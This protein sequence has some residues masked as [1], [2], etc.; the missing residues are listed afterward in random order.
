[1][2]TLQLPNGASS[3]HT[4][5]E[6]SHVLH[7]VSVP[8][9]EVDKADEVRQATNTSTL[10]RRGCES[11]FRN[12]SCWRQVETAW[13]RVAEIAHLGLLSGA[14]CFPLRRLHSQHSRDKSTPH[15]GR[16]AKVSWGVSGYSRGSTAVRGGQIARA[17]QLCSVALTLRLSHQC[18]LNYPQIGR[19]HV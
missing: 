1:M 15:A 14:L 6:W 10:K 18:H 17:M 19:A 13:Q 4:P 7:G 2:N 11:T 16:T 5:Y 8:K 12:T 9:T 3:R